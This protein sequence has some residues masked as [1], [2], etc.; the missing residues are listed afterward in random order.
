MAGLQVLPFVTDNMKKSNLIE[1]CD[2]TVQESQLKQ[3]QVPISTAAISKMAH[4]DMTQCGWM[5]G[6]QFVKH[7]AKDII[8]STEPLYRYHFCLA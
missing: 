5:A 7:F 4:W 6:L 2:G 3:V 1:V 8:F